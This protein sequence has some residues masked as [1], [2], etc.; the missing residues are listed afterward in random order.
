MRRETP[1]QDEDDKRGRGSESFSTGS[2]E[3]KGP[4]QTVGGGG[5]VVKAWSSWESGRGRVE[6][7]LVGQLQSCRVL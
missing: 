3:C 4:K 6:E 1:E 5:N 7:V 2:R